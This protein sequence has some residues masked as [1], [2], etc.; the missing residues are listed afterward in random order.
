MST[1]NQNTGWQDW[2]L[3]KEEKGLRTMAKPTALQQK[4]KLRSTQRAMPSQPIERL[5]TPQEHRL[6]P[7]LLCRDFPDWYLYDQRG[8][9]GTVVNSARRILAI[10]R[11]HAEITP[12]VAKG[13]DWVLTFRCNGKLIKLY[14]MNLCALLDE[15]ESWIQ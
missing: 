8:G 11:A 3:S 15:L 14:N 13:E 5:P 12:P 10:E 7:S 2:M 4:I 1:P 6:S 9:M